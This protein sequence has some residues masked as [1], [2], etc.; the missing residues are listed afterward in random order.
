[1]PSTHYWSGT[2]EGQRVCGDW[3]QSIG[4]KFFTFL[5]AYPIESLKEVM[6]YHSQKNVQTNNFACICQ[7]FLLEGWYMRCGVAFDCEL[8]GKAAM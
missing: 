5:V 7:C 2:I 3:P 4:Q 1:M 8:V 6:K